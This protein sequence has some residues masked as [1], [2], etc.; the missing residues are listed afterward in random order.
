MGVWL[1]H[2]G[3]GKCITLLPKNLEKKAPPILSAPVPAYKKGICSMSYNYIRKILSGASNSSCIMVVVVEVI[4]ALVVLVLTVVLL[5]LEA[6]IVV[7]AVV[8]VVILP[9]IL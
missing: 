5:T 6:V 4:A 8:A 7:V 2:D 9:E 1:P 3:V